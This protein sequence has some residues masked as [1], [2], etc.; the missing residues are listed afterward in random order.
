MCFD[1][2]RK[3]YNVCY[4]SKTRLKEEISKIVLPMSRLELIKFVPLPP[5]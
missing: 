5:V 4:I 2:I 1:I 3:Q